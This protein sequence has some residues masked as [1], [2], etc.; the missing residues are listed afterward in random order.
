M[1]HLVIEAFISGVGWIW[2]NLYYQ[3]KYKREE[4]LNEKHQGSYKKAG[5]KIIVLVFVL[6]L[7]YEILIEFIPSH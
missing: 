2:L 5:S 4:V 6:I 1:H 7:V 3:D